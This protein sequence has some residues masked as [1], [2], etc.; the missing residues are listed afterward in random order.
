MRRTERL[1]AG[2]ALLFPRVTVGV[3]AVSLPEAETIVIE[4]HETADPFHAFPGVQMGNDQADGTA[5]SAVSG[6]SSWSNAKSTLG[7]N[8]S[9]KGT[10]AV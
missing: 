3:I 1:L 10:L 7:R 4:K 2:V 8:K 6:S 9:G 5:N